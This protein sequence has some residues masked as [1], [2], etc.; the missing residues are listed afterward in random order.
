MEILTKFTKDFLCKKNT[1]E[2]PYKMTQD[3][4]K[5]DFFNVFFKEVWK[6]YKEILLKNLNPR[7]PTSL[8]RAVH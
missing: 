1:C 3:K 8:A 4:I 5:R 2:I 6:I 7:N